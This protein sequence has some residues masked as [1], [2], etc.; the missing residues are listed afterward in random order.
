M[1]RKSRLK[2]VAKRK[3]RKRR[4]PVSLPKQMEDAIQEMVGGVPAVNMADE[5][6][7]EQRAAR[8]VIERDPSVPSGGVDLLEER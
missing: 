5:F 3:K 7:R 4:P 6:K 8:P 1:S 2:A